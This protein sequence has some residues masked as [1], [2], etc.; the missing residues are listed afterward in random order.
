MFVVAGGSA[1][2]HYLFFTLIEVACMA[3]IVRSVWIRRPSR[4]TDAQRVV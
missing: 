3:M 2:L 1:D 4:T